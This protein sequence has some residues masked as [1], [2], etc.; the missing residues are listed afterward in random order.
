[1]TAMQGVDAN[2]TPRDTVVGFFEDMNA[3]RYEEAFG[4]VA[5]DA[6]FWVAGREWSVGGDYDRAGV[7]DVF[8]SKVGPRLTRPLETKVVGVTAEGER[9]AVEVEGGGP[10]VDGGQYANQFHFLFVVRDGQIVSTRE[11]HDTLHASLV[12]GP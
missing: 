2:R 12:I 8:A 7:Q 4:R 6:K 9:V 11:Y 1:M 5:P 3:G 10:T